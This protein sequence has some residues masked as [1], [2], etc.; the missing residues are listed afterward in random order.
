VVAA[1]AA[2]PAAATTAARR[3]TGRMIGCP[4]RMR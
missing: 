4:F 3:E 1:V 2:R